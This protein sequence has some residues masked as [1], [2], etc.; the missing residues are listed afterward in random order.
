VSIRHK[1]SSRVAAR[2]RAVGDERAEAM[3]V[4][5]DKP[6]G[7]ARRAPDRA[8]GPGDVGALVAC[9]LR[10]LGEQRLRR[11]VVER[12][13]G[14]AAAVETCGDTRRE[15]TEASVAV[16]QDDRPP[17]GS[18][19]DSSSTTIPRLAAS[20]WSTSTVSATGMSSR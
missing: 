11:L 7:R 16:V 19:S 13:P 2:P 10:K 15:A 5:S 1:L 18:S 6:V 17:H 8:V 9:R 3:A 12:Q 20:A 4:A 14:V